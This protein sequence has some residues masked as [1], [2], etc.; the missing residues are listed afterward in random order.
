MER[1]LESY[2]FE[3]RRA[4]GLAAF[5]AEAPGGFDQS[6]V[7]LGPRVGKKHFARKAHVAGI[8]F[9]SECCLL[10]D[11]IEIGN[12]EQLSCLFADSGNDPRVAVA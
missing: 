11:L 3:A 2:N 6:I 5:M 1:L 10:G 12:V 7:S 9:L 8:D 4:I